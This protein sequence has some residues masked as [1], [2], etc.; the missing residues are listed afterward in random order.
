MNQALT[1]QELVI[2]I[3]AKNLKPS[4]LNPDFLKYTGIIPEDWEFSDKPI[5]KNNVVRIA[6]KNN[7]N[8]IAQGNRLMFAEAIGKK[9]SDSVL[10]PEIARKFAEKLP[11]IDFQAVG[12]NPRGFVA[13]DKE[14]AARE[15]M[16][17]KLLSPGGWN[18]VGEAPMQASLNLVYKLER[19]PLSLN[20]SEAALKQEN[21]RIPLVIFSGSFGYEIGSNSK[22]EKLG[23]INQLI[24]NWFADVTTFSDLVN[25]KFMNQ[26]KH[27]ISLAEMLENIPEAKAEEV[28]LFAV[29]AGA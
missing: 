7:V 28:D 10:V 20:I 23:L 3:A 13:F 4:I 11:N 21:K 24:G 15:F 19:G 16:T 26:A 1:V 2:A 14:G 17:Q 18:D 29:G 22:E 27:H 6:F 12:I 8:I 25:N 9:S 5:F